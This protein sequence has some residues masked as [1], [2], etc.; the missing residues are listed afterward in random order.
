MQASSACG[1][2]TLRRDLGRG[3]CRDE[4]TPPFTGIY[5][6]VSTG[7]SLQS[8]PEHLPPPTTSQWE[9][10]DG[11]PHWQGRGF[12]VANR[13]GG[14]G[15]DGLRVAQGRMEWAWAWE[16]WE[17]PHSQEHWTLGL[18]CLR[19]R[20]AVWGGRRLLGRDLGMGG[21]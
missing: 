17:Q 21:R 10:A 12:P 18:S 2:E 20:G 11:H 6:W 8:V 4:L 3:L 1:L 19:L 5:G 16:G 14:P 15:V 13:K 9:P 7:H